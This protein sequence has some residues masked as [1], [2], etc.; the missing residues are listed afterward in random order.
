[1]AARC[2][3]ETPIGPQDAPR[4]R[5]EPQYNQMGPGWLQDVAKSSKM[6]QSLLQ[7]GFEMLQ[8]ASKESPKMPPREFQDEA[9]GSNMRPRVPRW[10]SDV[11]K[12]PQ[13]SLKIAR[14]RS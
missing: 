6:A 3:Q 4:C 12:T 1:M 11:R 14:E 13:D 10:L 9:E 8:D 2:T 7:D 5:Q